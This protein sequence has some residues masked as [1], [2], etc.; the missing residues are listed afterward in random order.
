MTC[1]V[2]VVSNVNGILYMGNERFDLDYLQDR[3]VRHLTT[4]IKSQ[5]VHK[6]YAFLVYNSPLERL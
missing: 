5:K 6:T 3:N 2:S 1:S 4:C